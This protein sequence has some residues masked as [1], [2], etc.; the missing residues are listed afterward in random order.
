MKSLV[1][2]YKNKYPGSHVQVSESALDVY[3]QDGEHLIAL[4]KNGAGQWNCESEAYGCP[5]RHDLAPIPKDARLYKIVEGKLALDDQH[6]ER[7]EKRQAF[8]KDGK[9]LSI[10]ELKKLGHKF[11]EAGRH[12]EAPKA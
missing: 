7:R 4:R 10:D 8:L 3:S 2:H 11:D 12:L 1:A 5:E 9:I 6:A